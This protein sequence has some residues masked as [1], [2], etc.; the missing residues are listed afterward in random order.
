MPPIDISKLQLSS[1]H[2]AMLRN[3]L[4]TYVPD[5]DVWAYGSRVTGGAHEGS[6]LDLV[7][8]HRLDLKQSV[9]GYAELI[10][11]LQRSDLPMLVQ[12]HVWSDLP[13]SFHR[14]IEACYVILQEDGV[15]A[16]VS[17]T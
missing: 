1:H 12:A 2:L 8:R 5:A 16:K 9:S 11:G 10:E 15:P 13:E 14:N 6:D 7:L 3:L 4:A 17:E